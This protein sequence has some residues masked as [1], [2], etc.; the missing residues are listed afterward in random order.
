MDAIR[1]LVKAINLYDES[2]KKFEDLKE[3]V[4]EIS[5]QQIQFDNPLTKELLYIASQ[6]LRT[7]GYN[8]LNNLSLPSDLEQR[9]IT[10]VYKNE[11]INEYYTTETGVQLD[12][13]QKNIIDEF[14][15]LEKKRMLVSAPTSFGKTFLLREIIFQNQKIYKNILLVFPTISLL[16]ENV[17]N[18]Y[19]FRRKHKI[20]YEIINNTHME[21]VSEQNIFILTPERVL[22][23]L[24]DNP[25]LK[26]DFFFMD[27]VYKIDNFF[28]LSSN[29]GEEDENERD[30]VFRI[31]LY[32]LSKQ[33]NDYYLAGP[34]IDLGNIGEG[35]SNFLERNEITCFQIDTEL[36][37]KFHIK[38]W[39]SLIY[40]NDTQ[41]IKYNTST[42]FGKLQEIID[43]INRDKYG[44]TIIY[45]ESKPKLSK[46]ARECLDIF[47]E[48]KEISKELEM[49]INHLQKRYSVKHKDKQ[50]HKYW[51][52]ISLMKRGVG[53]HHG[54]FPKYIQNAILYF[55]NNQELDFLFSTTSITEGVNT[56]A[57]NVIFYGASKGT[58][59]LKTFD[60]KNINGR[61]GRYY[62]HFVGRIF[63]LEKKIYD[64]L[65]THDDTLDFITF[66]EREIPSIDLDN[67][68]KEDLT[69]INR[70]L[71]E[72]RESEL[73]E[74]NI[75]ESFFI[76]NRLVDRFKQVELIKYL[77]SK[78]D[79]KL[80]EYIHDCSNI[81]NF[82]ASNTIYRILGS[83]KEVGMLDEWAVKKYGVTVSSYS[84][85]NGLTGLID[86]HINNEINGDTINNEIIDKVY[87]KVFSDI[88]NIIEYKIP[89]YLSVFGS[90]LKY[91]CLNRNINS[92]SIS[93]ESIIRFFE[94]GVTT[95]FGIMLAEN[96]YPVPT[97]K[98]LERRI[99]SLMNFEPSSII[100]HWNEINNEFEV[101][102]DEYEYWL[103]EN[104][105]NKFI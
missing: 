28:N 73:E 104:L 18:F 46:L 33:I 19:E 39:G 31:V 44:Q 97:I 88:R 94:L 59:K 62:H 68:E 70:K 79:E 12:K 26:F 29:L 57:K 42:K 17:D 51:T 89:K 13:F 5:D 71:K 98:V 38:A 50:T 43:L 67:T 65:Q 80:Q 66:G 69:A 11:V 64:Q 1:K 99:K 75:D 30:K 25:S 91:V 60:I 76:K 86:Y 4:C 101:V 27:E 9:N 40:I 100:N 61:A 105:I 6:K 52:I 78:S 58:K 10:Y 3:I 74:Y 53:I 81:R 37:N 87:I 103:M 7:F 92:E 55:F 32:L 35:F 102:L 22:K 23:L 14:Q 45:G 20:P 95:E 85:G 72:E 24:S 63:Y 41:K 49:F 47:P 54:S 16:N 36:V 2:D 34:Y 21:I 8:K 96:G 93:L 48:K 77:D 82:I 83:F 84:I 90:I 56:T 15:T